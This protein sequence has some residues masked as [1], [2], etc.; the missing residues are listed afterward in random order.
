MKS[1]RKQ[2]TWGSAVRDFSRIGLGLLAIG[3][4]QGNSEPPDDSLFR[5]DLR[6]IDDLAASI[7]LGQP[8]R[9]QGTV[10][11]GS[12]LVINEVF[13]HGAD[14]MTDPDFIELYNGGAGQVNLRGYQVRD[15]GAAWAV[16]PAEAVIPAGGYFVILCDGLMSS[17]V[18]G[19]HVS[20]KLGG[21]GDEVHL[22]S[23][24]GAELDSVMWGSSSIDIPKDKSLG[25]VPDQTGRWMVLGK[26]SRGTPN[27]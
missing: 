11:P 16:L 25:R 23:P 10:K 22:A 3:C 17:G 4:S 1:L 14:A 9:D 24:D 13:P 18:P 19:T 21:S 27:Q 2:P 7:D 5:V 15:D 20:F 6:S 12:P 26:P 8:P